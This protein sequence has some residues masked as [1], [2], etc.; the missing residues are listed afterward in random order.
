MRTSDKNALITGA[1]RG[2]G[3]QL[4][5][6]L[7]ELGYNPILVGRNSDDLRLVADDIHSST[8]RQTSI[9]V[10]D[11]TDESKIRRMVNDLEEKLLNIHILVNN[12][13]IHRKGTLELQENEFQELLEVNLK[14]HFLMTRAIVPLM[15]RNGNGYIFNIASRSAKVGFADTGGYCA[16]KWGLLG[17]SESLYHKLTPQGIKVTALCPAWVDTDMARRADSPL[18]PDEMIEPA[19]L[20]K[21]IEWLLSLSSGACV[22]EIVITNPKSL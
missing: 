10:V 1:S 2:I 14:A 5:V 18:H 7:A 19:D 3:R 21:T 11:I 8:G 16:S 17:L 13:G 4:A 20:S 12:A 9:Y 6:S 15:L 22:K